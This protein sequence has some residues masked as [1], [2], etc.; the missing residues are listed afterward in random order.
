M[1]GPTSRGCVLWSTVIATQRVEMPISEVLMYGIVKKLQGTTE[2]KMGVALLATMVSSGCYRYSQV[3][4]ETIRQ[5]ESVRVVVSSNALAGVSP[6]TTQRNDNVEGDLMDL[7]SDSAAVAIWIGQAF[8]GTQFQMAHQT[9]RIPRDRIVQ[10]QRRELSGW[11]T[12]LAAAAVTGVV[13]T[14]IRE[15]AFEEDPNPGDG[16]EPPPPPPAGGVGINLPGGLR[17]ILGR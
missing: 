14:L 10:Y 13:I 11:R 4:P 6:T 3:D 9:L 8:R 7:T 15:V 2:F 1:N 16:S 12:A 5:G 17:M